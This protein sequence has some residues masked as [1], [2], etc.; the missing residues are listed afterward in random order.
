MNSNA[1]ILFAMV[2]IGLVV[3]TC[4]TAEPILTFLRTATAIH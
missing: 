3:T 4:W 2:A 1:R